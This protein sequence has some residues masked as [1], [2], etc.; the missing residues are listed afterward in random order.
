[1]DNTQLEP[2]RSVGFGSTAIAGVR[3]TAVAA[4]AAQ[5]TAAVQ[6][7]YVMA[8]QRPRNFD[9]VR[10][11]LLKECRRPSFAES[12]RYALPRTA[13]D[14]TTRT[15]KEVSIE[16]YSIRFAEA[17]LRA[18][19]NVL[20]ETQVVYEDD[21]KRIVRVSVTDL[22]SN[23]TYPKDVTVK[24]TVERKTLRR[25]QIALSSRT[26][27]DGEIVHLIASTD[28]EL[29][30]K[31]NALISRAI[32]TNGLRLVPGDLLDECEEQ[33]EATL[34]SRDKS[35][36]DAA[37]KKLLDA[38][39]TIG[40]APAQLAE[41]LGHDTREISADEVK[42]LRG[43][44]TALKDGRTTWQ[45]VMDD[46]N[47]SREAFGGGPEGGDAAQVDTTPLVKRLA[48]LRFT[49]AP[50]AY[51]AVLRNFAIEDPAKASRAQLE[52]AIAMLTRPRASGTRTETPSA[53]TAPT[54][55]PA[56]FASRKA[57]EKAAK[58]GAK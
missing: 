44:Y 34:T 12:A 19:K 18:L 16:G 49:E 11:D 22:E 32:R 20:I 56:E 30:M 13:W 31:E 6:A 3:E 14:A 57:A 8:T 7:R 42:R 10:M 27:S 54:E 58:D 9:Q 33:I 5:A 23:V 52:Q 24:K 47:D 21:E 2:V 55:S 38:F 37:R 43:V 50:D 28:D 41:F 45:D 39:G 1:M 15:R 29:L 46:L 36:P 48:E 40:V 51:A 53:P 25:G 35:D 4:A 26:G 17:A